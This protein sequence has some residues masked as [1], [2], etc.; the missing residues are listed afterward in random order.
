MLLKEKQHGGQVRKV[1]IVQ[2]VIKQYR[3]PFYTKLARRLS[4][5][6]IELTVLY[7]EPNTR[8]AMRAD[9]VARPEPFFRAVRSRWILGE[10]LLYQ[11]V[12]AELNNAEFVIIEHATKY[13]SNYSLMACSLLGRRRVALWGHGRNRQA[14]G[15]SLANWVRRQMMRSADWYFAYTAGTRD[16]VEAAG[17]PRRRI[18]VVQ[19]A[20]DTTELAAQVESVT[21]DE[22]SGA[23]QA[24]GVGPN[25]PVGLFVGSLYPDKLLPFLIA[26]AVRV[27][28]QCPTFHLVIAGAGPD[29]ESVVEA[30]RQH[31]NWIHYMGPQFGRDRAVYFRMATAF[32]NP[33]LVGLAILDAFAAGLPVITTE[34]P[35]HSPEIEYL[36]PGVNGLVTGATPEAYATTVAE[37]MQSAEFL[38][39]LRCGAI[40]TAKSHSIEAMVENFHEGILAWV[41]SS[42]GRLSPA[43]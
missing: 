29:A 27:R 42:G 16:Y 19:N 38:K 18:T 32:V 15:R 35:Y 31:A 17:I 41:S 6:G 1:C 21:D 8:D 20:T 39:R 2:S 26:S 24:L 43:L 11:S 13:L 3:V 10:R 25:D 36:I 40:E 34:F 5:D 37:L 22:L 33:G 9:N 28:E 14:R 12:E 7:G 23:R 4:S 30:A